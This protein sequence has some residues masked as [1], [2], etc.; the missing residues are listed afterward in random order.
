LSYGLNS[1]VGTGKLTDAKI[2]YPAEM[3]GLMD[4]VAYTIPYDA[5]LAG[6]RGRITADGTKRTARHSEGCNQ[7][8]MDGHVKWIAFDNIPDP[9]GGTH[10][11]KSE[12]KHYW[13]GTD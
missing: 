3:L 4:A 2:T 12:A 1:C 7:S 10:P 6:A 13:Q 5:T 8:Y 9:A 11:A